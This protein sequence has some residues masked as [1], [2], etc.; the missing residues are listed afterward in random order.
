MIDNFIYKITL[1][2]SSTMSK[3]TIFL[4]YTSILLL[5]IVCIL[6]LL[7]GFLSVEKSSY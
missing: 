6:S 2:L 5:N 1:Y 3:I 7:V 4:D